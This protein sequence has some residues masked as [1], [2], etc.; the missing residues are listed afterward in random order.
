MKAASE[1]KLNGA[2][3]KVVTPD[4]MEISRLRAEHGRL[5]RELELIK[6]RRRTSQK[7][8]GEGRLDCR[9]R[10]VVCPVDAV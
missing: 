7:R 4:E 1:G 6:K 5:K 3:S 10:P 9:A 2:G 8:P